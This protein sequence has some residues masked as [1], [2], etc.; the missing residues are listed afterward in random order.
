MQSKYFHSTP[1]KE[2]CP[3]PSFKTLLSLMSTI[4][5]IAASSSVDHLCLIKMSSSR[6]LKIKSKI[7]QASQRIMIKIKI[8][9]MIK[10]SKSTLI[11]TMRK[12][13]TKGMITKIIEIMTAVKAYKAVGP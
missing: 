12:T 6:I 10:I 4:I 2:N 1:K 8:K 5:V 3:N 11:K 7:K 13:L 9:N